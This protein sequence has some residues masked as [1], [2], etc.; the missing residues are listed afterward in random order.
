MPRVKTSTSSPPRRWRLQATSPPSRSQ[1][2]LAWHSEEITEAGKQAGFT[3]DN[4]KEAKV[5]LKEKGLRSSNQGRF[6]GAWWTGFGDPAGWKLRPEDA[7]LPT[8]PLAFLRGE[9]RSPRRS[10]NCKAQPACP[11]SL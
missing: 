7:T 3:F 6:Q 5:R 9:N 2:S 10:Q 4:L 11:A 8:P 1:T